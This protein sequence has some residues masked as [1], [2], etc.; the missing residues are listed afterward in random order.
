MNIDRAIDMER[1]NATASDHS[2]AG[3]SGKRNAVT[4]QPGAVMANKIV[5][6][7]RTVPV[8]SK[9]VSQTTA[10]LIKKRNHAVPTAR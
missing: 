3:S 10:V 7:I 1:L 2:I 6:T 5:A 8:R 4:V 9:I